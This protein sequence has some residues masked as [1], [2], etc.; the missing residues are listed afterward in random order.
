MTTVSTDY[1]G[2]TVDLLIFQ[3]VQAIGN[4]KL[5]LGFGLAGEVVTGIQKLVQTFT[6]MFLTAQGSILYLPAWGTNFVP[7]L[8]QGIIRDESTVKSEFQFAVELIRQALT[9]EAAEHD[10]P[11]DESYSSATLLNYTINTNTGVLSLQIQIESLAGT[12]NTVY[13]PI[14]VPVL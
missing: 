4:R 14:P 12:T 1:T 5:T 9:S 3:G 10:I 6:T 8:Q 7:H 13:L 2:R 11:A